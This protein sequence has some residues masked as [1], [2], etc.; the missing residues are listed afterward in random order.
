MSGFFYEDLRAAAPR[1]RGR[2]QRSNTSGLLER[3]G[4]R[5]PTQVH[6]ALVA[7]AGAAE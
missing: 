1:A 3:P 2:R 4:H 7:F 6:A 5:T